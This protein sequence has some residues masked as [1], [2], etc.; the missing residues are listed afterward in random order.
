MV[1][2]DSF[3]S[4]LTSITRR[5]EEGTNVR[6]CVGFRTP[7]SQAYPRGVTAGVRK[8]P[9]HEIAGRGTDWAVP[10]AQLWG[11]GRV[12]ATAEVGSEVG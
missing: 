10:R 8:A 6:S 3:A 5:D 9:R 1:P 2:V 7:A 11:F 4:K 12:R